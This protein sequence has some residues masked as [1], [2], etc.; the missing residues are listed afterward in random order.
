MNEHSLKQFSQPLNFPVYTEHRAVKW[1]SFFSLILRTEHLL[2]NHRSETLCYCNYCAP[3][4][5]NTQLMFY[6]AAISQF[7]INVGISSSPRLNC[8]SLKHKSSCSQWRCATHSLKPCSTLS[9]KV[10]SWSSFILCSPKL[11]LIHQNTTK[12]SFRNALPFK[13]LRF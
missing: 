5:Q 10:W 3:E 13:E 12:Q 6:I 4:L 8:V 1:A 7:V 9:F 11:H 2:M